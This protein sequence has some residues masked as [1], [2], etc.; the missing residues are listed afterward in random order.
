MIRQALSSLHQKMRRL[1][2]PIAASIVALGATGVGPLPLS[3]VF[4]GTR[5]VE[6]AEKESWLK[7]HEERGGHTLARHVGKDEAWLRARLESDP[8][9]S[10]ASSFPD[11]AM[12]E[13]VIIAAGN[14][15]RDAIAEWLRTGRVGS[16][17]TVDYQGQQKI[18]I[19]VSRR[20]P[21]VFDCFRARIVLQSFKGPDYF[22]LTAYP[23]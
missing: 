2:L 16:R 1:A 8:K 9:L 13:K 6:A 11:V 10:R 5:T 22:V 3:T 17:L 19:V 18:G 7:K 4:I 12:A 23:D 14:A 21:R 15:N 20:S